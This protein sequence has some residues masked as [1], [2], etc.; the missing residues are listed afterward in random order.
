M[1]GQMG[2]SKD[3]LGEGHSQAWA[4]G[5][6]HSECCFPGPGDGKDSLACWFRST[7]CRVPC[8]FLSGGNIP[9]RKHWAVTSAQVQAS[10]RRQRSLITM[11]R[12]E[13]LEDCGLLSWY[14][15][16]SRRSGGEQQSGQQA[17][18]NKQITAE[19]LKGR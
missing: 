10:D 18:E 14:P 15:G 16:Q 9:S 5:E 12:L 2:S 1:V 17:C 7:V 11:G 4:G 8:C 13:G 6:Q 19:R 3:M